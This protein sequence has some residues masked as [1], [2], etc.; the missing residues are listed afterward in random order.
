MPSDNSDEILS[1]LDSAIA[2]WLPHFRKARWATRDVGLPL[3]YNRSDKSHR[4]PL[5]YS[6]MSKLS[7]ILFY[8]TIG[9]A[10]CLCNRSS[11]A[12]ENPQ[13][14]WKGR[15][16]SQSTGHSGP[17][18][19]VIS[20]TSRGTYQARFTGRFAAVIPFAYR[21]DLV[22]QS[23]SDGRTILTSSKKLGPILGSYQMQ[24]EI[25]GNVLSGDFQAAGDRGSI[26]MQRVGR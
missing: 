14:V 7:A 2:S 5:N 17:M 25:N 18:R 9:L 22:P 15:W 3:N 26:M 13:G 11:V 6:T 21:A 20:P 24:T 23:T 19:V 10:I 8:A 1:Q 4:N 12:Q 16:Q